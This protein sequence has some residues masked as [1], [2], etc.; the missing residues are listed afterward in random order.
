MTYSTWRQRPPTYHTACHPI[1][2]WSYSPNKGNI[3]LSPNVR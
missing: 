1:A 2:R 3:N